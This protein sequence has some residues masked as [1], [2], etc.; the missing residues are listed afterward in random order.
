MDIDQ[1]TTCLPSWDVADLPEPQPASRRNWTAL[2][3]PG[4]VMCGIQLAGGEWLFG[5]EITARYGGG[6]M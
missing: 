6:L 4:I 5:P 2:L 1:P 3:G